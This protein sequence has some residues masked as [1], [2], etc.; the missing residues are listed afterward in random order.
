MNKFL[1]KSFAPVSIFVAAFL[2]AGVANA[3]GVGDIVGTV[4]VESAKTALIAIGTTLG[5]LLGVGIAVR[6][7]L[8]LM[9]R[10]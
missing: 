4:D 7:V 2:V 1:K 9:K 10:L 3:A 6:Y 5:G 8:G